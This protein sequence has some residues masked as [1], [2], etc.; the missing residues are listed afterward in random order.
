MTTAFRPSFLKTLVVGVTAAS[1][2]ILTDTP[3]ILKK[4]SPKWGRFR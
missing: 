1:A 4:L 3:E 2:N